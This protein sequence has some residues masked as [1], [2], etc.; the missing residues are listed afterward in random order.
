V[1]LLRHFSILHQHDCC[2]EFNEAFAEWENKYALEI[3]EEQS[4]L[5]SLGYVG[6]FRSKIFK[7]ARYYLPRLEEKEKGDNKNIHISRPRRTYSSISSELSAKIAEYLDQEEHYR[8]KPSNGFALFCQEY[9]EETIQE[10]KRL[11]REEAKEEGKEEEVVVVVE[12]G[13]LDTNVLNRQALLKIKKTFKN[14]HF[15]KKKIS[16]SS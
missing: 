7:T 9:R 3:R 6:D 14:K 2:K 10:L 13:A 8:L 11:R 15:I 5:E 12:D 16:L 4:Y 1:T